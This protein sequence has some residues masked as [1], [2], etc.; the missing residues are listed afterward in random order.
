MLYLEQTCWHVRTK[1]YQ[2]CDK[3]M[4]TQEETK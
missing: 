2:G 3:R 4:L 1:M